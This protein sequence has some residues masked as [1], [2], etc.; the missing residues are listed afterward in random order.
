[1]SNRFLE[2]G[3]QADE[4]EEEE[5][6]G[7]RDPNIIRANR[8]PKRE[9]LK[10]EQVGDLKNKWKTGEVEAAQDTR[11]DRTSELDELKKGL[12][13]KER[14]QEKSAADQADSAADRQSVVE[15]EAIDTSCKRFLFFSFLPFILCL[16]AT[17]D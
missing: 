12:K 3:G 5:D 8:R 1:M 14:F 13:V 11:E 16:I 7:D 9:E 17:A 2:G 10:F 4:P 15:R 6:E